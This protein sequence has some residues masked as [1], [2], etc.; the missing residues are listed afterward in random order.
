MLILCVPFYSAEA[1]LSK[2]AKT[3]APTDEIEPDRTSEGAGGNVDIAM[4]DP[5]P[6]G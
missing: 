2:K 6:Q 3:N 1:R 5:V 4:D